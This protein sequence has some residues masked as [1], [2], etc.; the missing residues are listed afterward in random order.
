MFAKKIVKRFGDKT[1][2][3]IE[4]KPWRLGEMRGVGPK[5]IA[6]VIAGVKGHRDRLEVM[7]FLHGQLGPVRAQRVFEHYGVEARQKI[8]ADPYR[9]MDD[10]A[11]FGWVLSDRVARDVGVE[12]AHPRRLQ[13]AVAAALQRGANLGHTRLDERT[14]LRWLEY[15]LGSVELAR[16][17]GFVQQTH[18]DG[19]R[20]IGGE[21]AVAHYLTA[22]G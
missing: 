20:L 7:A 13:A 6:G 10:F 12:E 2:H 19:V 5:R 16:P 3:V 1:L 8:A 4:H 21:D 18:S 22:R 14:C 15:L 17:A 11:G 9:L